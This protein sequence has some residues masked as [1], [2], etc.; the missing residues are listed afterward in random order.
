ML[1]N[2]VEAFK[3]ESKGFER[4]IGKL[5]LR[6]G[7]QSMKSRVCDWPPRPIARPHSM[8]ENCPPIDN[9]GESVVPRKQ[10]ARDTFQRTP[11]IFKMIIIRLPGFGSEQWVQ[12]F[13]SFTP[14]ARD[15]E[16]KSTGCAAG[17]WKSGS[18]LFWQS[19]CVKE[20]P[21]WLADF[22]T[23]CFAAEQASLHFLPFPTISQ[24]LLLLDQTTQFVKTVLA[25]KHF[26]FQ[27]LNSFYQTKK[28]W[29]YAP[30]VNLE[31]IGE[32]CCVLKS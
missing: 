2:W 20:V 10:K 13:Q 26:C 29:T 6:K 31:E 7:N 25:L 14:G 5:M 17:R 19:L 21:H 3:E 24:S 15:L 28:D 18:D 12:H 8:C 1:W 22:Q 27:V 30:T 32:K 9:P 23:T 4:Q 11:L 16:P